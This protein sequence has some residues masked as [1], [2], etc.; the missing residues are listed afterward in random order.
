MPLPTDPMLPPMFMLPR[1]IR[2]FLS[3]NLTFRFKFCS[4]ALYFVCH[5][6]AHARLL[7]TLRHPASRNLLSC[8]PKLAYKYL[9]NY[10]ALNLSTKAR[11][12]LL[13]AH[14]QFVQKRLAHGFLDAVAAAAVTLWSR[15]HGADRAAIELSFPT[16]FH[17]EGDLCLTLTLNGKKIYRIVLIIGGGG[18]FGVGDKDVLFITCIQGLVQPDQIKHATT[19]CGTVHPSNLMMAAASGLAQAIGIDTLLGIRTA[20]Q[21]T[22]RDHRYFSYDDFFDAYGTLTSDSTAYAIALP[23]ASKE[24]VSIKSKH[25]TRV[26]ERREFKSTVSADIRQSMAEFIV[27]SCRRARIRSE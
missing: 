17:G 13:T 14:Y 26:R 10:A 3:G 7:N 16:T 11:R 19:C 20:N 12:M 9:D 27:R 6:P 23:L 22:C 2:A 25:R 1:L 8:H 24:L 4:Q 18:L 21:I 5:L 15:D